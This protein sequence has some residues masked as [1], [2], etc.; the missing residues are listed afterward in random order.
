MQ[1]AQSPAVAQS[2]RHVSVRRHSLRAL[3]QHRECADDAPSWFRLSVVSRR[4]AVR[5]RYAA[6]I[7][8]SAG[9]REPGPWGS[10]RSLQL[11]GSGLDAGDIVVYQV[12]TYPTQLLTPPAA[13]SPAS[14]GST[15]TATVVSVA[16]V[17]NSITV[18]L[19]AVL[20]TDVAYALWVQNSQGEWSNAVRIN[21]ARPL[22]ISPDSAYATATMASLPRQLEVIGRNLQPAPGAVTQVRLHGPADFVLQ[23]ANDNDPTTTIERYV[24]K[25]SLPD[26][27][28]TGSYGV[29]VSRDGL[30]WISL[31]GNA[32]HGALRPCMPLQKFKVRD[33]G[34]LP[35][36]GIDDTA[37][38]T[39]RSSPQKATAGAWSGLESECGI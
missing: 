36:D 33:F 22:W 8:Q 31:D 14:D 21:D 38:V 29:E 20:R 15:G 13:V 12:I 19:P 26:S 39:G 28:P 16:D 9:L 37:C 30:N 25:V 35:G 23:A 17:P 5:T 24:A 10:R 6:N 32:V 3:I 27:L 34:C 2:S 7:V 11:V 4:D 18:K 1:T